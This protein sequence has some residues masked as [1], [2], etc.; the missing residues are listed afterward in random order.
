MDQA[1]LINTIL[2]FIVLAFSLS[3]HEFCHA[4]SAF[5]LG[6]ETAQ[7]EG[8]LSLN[9]INHL[10]PMGTVFLIF[11]A[12][13]GIGFGWAKPVPVNPAR[14]RNARKG[15]TLVAAAGPVSNF[16]LALVS[17]F[18][19]AL[20]MVL[21]EWIVITEGLWILFEDFLK[22]ALKVNLLLFVFNML[23]FYPL[24]GSKILSGLL[25]EKWAVQLDFTMIKWGMAPLGIL[26]LWEFFIPFPGPLS[27][28]LGP[29]YSSLF[30]GFTWI[31]GETIEI[32]QLILKNA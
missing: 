20:L 23:P 32:L 4:Y 31:H 12:F 21:G 15:M 30:L 24:D 9:P 1:I 6:D 10:D 29:V 28:I 27:F 2:F 3:I 17:V 26:L 13:S 14:F 16:L 11:M 18:L 5:L 25:P 8:R 22:I 19:I 7:K